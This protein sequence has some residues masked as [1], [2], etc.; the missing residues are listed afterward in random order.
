M[1]LD[2]LKEVLFI[3]L[4]LFSVAVTAASTWLFLA[5]RLPSSYRIA[6]IGFPKS[7]KTTMITA[8]FAY[9]FRHGMKGASIVPRGEETIKRVNSNM[10]DLELG[11]SI[12]PT[13]D[14]DVFAYRAEINLSSPLFSRHYKLEIGD[15]PGEN[16]VAF[17][18]ET[19][20]WL[21]ETRYFD[22]AISGD[23]FLFVV[24]LGAV[25]E[26]EKGEY[27]ARQKRALRAAWQ[28]LEE[29]HLDSGTDIRRKPLILVFTKADLL[30]LG[31]FEQRRIHDLAYGIETPVPINGSVDD[32]AKKR[33]AVLKRFSDLIDY[34]R[35]ENKRFVVV[36]VSVFLNVN[37]ERLGIPEIASYIMPR[38]SLWPKSLVASGDQVLRRKITTRQ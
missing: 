16:T 12:G 26:D 25:L 10:E 36:F 7:G 24:D 2:L 17:A 28:R 1:S 30:L 35:R 8:V 5:R 37:G 33:D 13:T 22:W 32:I 21:H 19:G 11:R 4:L 15:F 38:W 31:S 18:E 23:A 34:F 9:L 20:D 29:H 3:A 6:V 14:Q 27:V